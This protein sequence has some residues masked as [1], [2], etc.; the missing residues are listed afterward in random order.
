MAASGT[1][2]IQL[3]Y[4]TTSGTAPVA[5]NLASGELAINI[6]DGKLYYK[7]NGGTV[8]I[9]G[10]KTTPTSAGGTGL[11]SF[12]ANGVLYA[13]G[14]GTLATGSAL[15][16]DGANLTVA[17][18]NLTLATNGNTLYTNYIANKIGRAHV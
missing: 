9:I 3:Y 1:Q 15:T 10:Y 17:N 5:T 16:F 18:G 14:T 2:T 12:T 8:Q 7:D 6:T 4:S 13:S 11:T